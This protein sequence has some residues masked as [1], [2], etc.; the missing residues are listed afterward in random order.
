MGQG[1]A[2]SC[3]ARLTLID[4]L[5]TVR[6]K[7]VLED[8]KLIWDNKSEIRKIGVGDDALLYVAFSQDTFQNPQSADGV[9]L[10]NDDKIYA[11][12]CTNNSFNNIN[13]SDIS[14]A[15]DGFSIGDAFFKLVI[16]NIHGEFVSIILKIHVSDTWN[17][18]S[19]E[20]SLK[21]LE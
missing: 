14:F 1:V 20:I 3:S 17:K 8:G 9:V 10:Q 12:I 6:R 11:K 13:P 2:E 15:E 4:V 7:P 21:N 5:S 16:R 18:L 19:M